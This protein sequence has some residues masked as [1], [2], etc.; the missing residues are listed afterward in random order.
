MIG[1]V[2]F[3]FSLIRNSLSGLF[4]ARH[5][6]GAEGFLPLLYLTALILM[7]L[8]ESRFMIGS[9]HWLIYVTITISMHSTV[10]KLSLENIIN[11]NN[12][13]LSR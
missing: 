5:V 13:V 8:S 11:K 1:L 6:Q 10:N 4:W 3:G 9:I 7:N 12:F 2:V